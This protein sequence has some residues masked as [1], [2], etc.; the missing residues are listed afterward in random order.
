MYYNK[1]IIT[2]LLII[3]TQTVKKFI[4]VLLLNK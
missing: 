1:D 2:T 3:I 4:F